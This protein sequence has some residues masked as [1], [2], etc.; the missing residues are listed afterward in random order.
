MLNNEQLEFE[1]KKLK[2]RV[3]KLERFMII[4]ERMVDGQVSL[5]NDFGFVKSSIEEIEKN[6]NSKLDEVLSALAVVLKKN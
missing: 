5:R 2:V 6:V 1:I 4:A 3:G